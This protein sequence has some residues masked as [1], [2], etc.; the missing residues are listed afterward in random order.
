MF[1]CAARPESAPYPVKICK[2][3]VAGD[4]DDIPPFRDMIP[5]G[6]AG[7]LV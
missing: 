7:D 1:Y 2:H 5:F 6:V 3:G 4:R